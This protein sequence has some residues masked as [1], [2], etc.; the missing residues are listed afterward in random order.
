MLDGAVE[1]L[2][3]A[4]LDEVAAE[5]WADRVEGE[6]ASLLA[7]LLDRASPA[8]AAA[9]AGRA[10]GLALLW[11]AGLATPATLASPLRRAIDEA[12]TEA[13]S[14]SSLA[15]PAALPARL[16][17]FDLARRRPGQLV[18]RLSLVAAVVS[19]RI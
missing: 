4:E 12:R 13:R 6:L 15:L 18:K 11:R 7:Q 8:G 5:R 2:E 9:A 10:W 16:A 17:R 14:L 3:L 19:G 1:A